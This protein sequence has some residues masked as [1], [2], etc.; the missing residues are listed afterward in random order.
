MT[1]AS[2]AP[3]KSYSLTGW[4]LAEL[5]PEKTAAAIDE[6]M[7]ELEAAVAAFESRR[8]ELQPELEPATF[9][10]LLRQYEA[11]VERCVVL[12][13]FVSLWFSSDT[14]S[15]NALTQQSRVHQALAAANN[16]ILFFDLWWK[17]RPEAEAQLL[18]PSEADEPDLAHYLRELRR[19]RPYSLDEKREQL[20]NLKDADGM[21]ALLTLYSMLTNRLEFELE[22]D[23]E[24]RTLTRDALV[25]YVYAGRREMRKAAYQELYRVYE[26]EA[27]P[28]AQIYASRVRDWHNENVQVRGFASPIAVRNVANDIPDAAVETLLAVCREHTGL[29]HRFF[30]LK[31]RALGLERLRRYDIYAPL[32]DSDIEIPYE[33]AVGRVLD[34]F[35]RFHPRLADLAERV[36]ADNHIDSEVRKGKRGGAFCASVLP[37]HTPWVL[38]NY[39]GRL[40][41]VQT[42]AHELGHAIHSMMAEEHSVLTQRS[43]L[44]LAETA[45]VF[46]EILMTDR[47]LAEERDPQARAELLASSIDDIYATV[48]RQAYF[49]LFEIDAHEAILAGKSAD[50]L[51]DLYQ[52]HLEEQFGDA[53]ELSDEFRSEWLSI[54]HIY[55]TPFY[56]YAYCFGQLLVLALYRRYQQEGEAFKPGYLKML[57]AGGAARPQEI[58][59]EVG[60]DVTDP[61][62]WRGGFEVIRGM[63]DELESTLDSIPTG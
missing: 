43:S 36:F 41:D 60:V 52:A 24:T 63:I 2:P 59:A 42:V 27:A 14:Q 11:L 19:L 58:L 16:R 20:V 40:R 30:R 28:L 29:F 8:G 49:V 45:S 34:T 57:A 61:E 50:E 6:R 21:E 39:T 13:S 10:D 44:P 23:G 1:I 3:L 22:V 46:A 54:P 47:L 33:E 9:L 38:V 32:A 37:Q 55:Q 18:M 56:C 62:F 53:V 26:K 31:A 51:S 5:I 4:S 7:V 48:L 17:A 12:D 15:Q 25:G 35:A